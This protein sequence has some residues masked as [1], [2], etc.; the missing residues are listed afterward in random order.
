LAASNGKS[1]GK[2]DLITA[3]SVAIMIMIPAI[4]P[5]TAINPAA[6]LARPES[7]PDALETVLR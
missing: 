1:A 3:M 6:P 7:I 2:N 4:T 5:V